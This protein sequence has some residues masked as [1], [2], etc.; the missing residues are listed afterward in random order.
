M[1]FA[2]WGACKHYHQDLFQRAMILLLALG[3][4]TGKPGGGIRIGAW[5][6]MTLTYD[7][8][9]YESLVKPAERPRVRDVER[10]MKNVMR[11]S[12]TTPTMMWLYA[13][14]EGYR[15]IVDNNAFHDPAIPRPIAEYCQEAMDKGWMPVWPKPPK[16]PRVFLFSGMNPLRRWPVPQVLRENM[17]EKFDLIVTWD[18]RMSSSGMQCDIILPAAG[19]H[20]KEGVKF[21][22]SLVPYICVGDKAVDPLFDSKPEWEIMGMLARTLEERARERETAPIVDSFGQERD[23]KQAFKDWSFNGIYTEHDAARAMDFGIQ[24]SEPTKDIPWADAAKQGAIR[25]KNPGEYGIITGMCSDYKIDEP[26]HPFDW[27]VKDKEPWPTLTGRQQFYLDHPWFLEVGEELPVH[28]EN[29]RLG[30][31]YPLLMTGGHT[32]WSIHAIWR[33]NKTLLR[34][35]R[36]EPV[37]YISQEDARRRGINDHDLIT[38]RND[39]G[40]FTVRAKISPQVQPG[41]IITYHAWE[42]YQ[43][44]GWQ[45]NQAVVASPFKP[46]HMVGNYGHLQ[47]RFA[48]GQPSQVPR[49]HA[50]EIERVS[51]LGQVAKGD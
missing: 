47:Y 4:H 31:D 2:S 44:P 8:A 17:W 38:V 24:M 9:V 51:A 34:L 33:A 20:E 21:T 12:T 16:H 29:P 28:K 46:L 25:V 5:W 39:V 45:S 23:L 26:V 27:F 13:H 22:Q 35:Q 43:F 30:G 36:G 37:A 42:P 3:A 41:Q 11:M 50:V 6:N 40:G 48:L 15:K 49:A 14:D 1:I 32:R 18:F 7:P 10:I 19:W